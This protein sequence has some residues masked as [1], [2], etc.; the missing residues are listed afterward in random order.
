LRQRW[1]R[2]SLTPL[3]RRLAAALAT[4]TVPAPPAPRD[5]DEPWAAVAVILSSTPDSVLLIRRAERPGDPWSG[6][7]GLPGG[8]FDPDDS[9]LVATAIRETAEEIGYTL[10]TEGLLGRLEDVWP[11]TPLPRM[12]V[13]R[14]YVFAV[15]GRGPVTPNPEVAEA[16]WVPL[17]E[18]RRPTVLRDTIVS[19]R[20]EDRT[21]PAYH[22]APG[23]VWGLTE[24]ILTSLLQVAI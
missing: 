22:L 4:R 20:G 18:L 24:R 21:F 23:T 1:V 8:R 12:I 17:A 15:T 16:F 13:V 3:Q 9:D 6:H 10:S 2:L 5:I 11:R 7:I 14:P 19:L